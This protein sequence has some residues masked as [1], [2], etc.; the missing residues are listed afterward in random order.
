MNRT[1]APDERAK[2]GERYFRGCYRVAVGAMLGMCAIAASTAIVD[3]GHSAGSSLAIIGALAATEI[4]ASYNKK[5][6][7]RCYQALRGRAYL[8]AT[9]ALLAVALAW[10]WPAVDQNALYFAVAGPIAMIVCVGQG[11]RDGLGGIA[12]IAAGTAAAAALDPALS[13]FQQQTTATFGLLLSGVLLK[14]VVQWS[15]TVTAEAAYAPEAA[16]PDLPPAKPGAALE[17][18]KGARPS[19]RGPL[20]A[21]ATAIAEELASWRDAI[22]E[23]LRSNRARSRVFRIVIG[24]PARE[25]QV[26]LLLHRYTQTDVAQYLSIAVATVRNTAERATARGLDGFGRPVSASTYS[27]ADLSRDL[28]KQYPTVADIGQ[29]AREVDQHADPNP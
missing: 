22:V 19:A 18:L 10:L 5:N 6:R 11:A 3:Q 8:L 25:L 13:G 15:A 4:V 2:V 20:T 26:L 7:T 28:S 24:F 17:P 29:L 1:I 21:R 9:P 12:L 27:R 14:L 16:A 23:L